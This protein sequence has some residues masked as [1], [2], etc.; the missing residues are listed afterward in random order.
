VSDERPGLD[1]LGL[2]M[3]WV[4]KITM[5]ALEMVL[6]ALGGYWLDKRNGTSYWAIIGVVVG[7]VAGMWHLLLMTR[8]SGSGN[9]PKITGDKSSNE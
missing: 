5:V 9:R 2:A 1:P 4:T 7:L 6:P 3:D 8:A